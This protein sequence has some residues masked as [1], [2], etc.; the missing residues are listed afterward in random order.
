MNQKLIFASKNK[1]GVHHQSLTVYRESEY[2]LR[3]KKNREDIQQRSA[4]KTEGAGAAFR[5]EQTMMHHADPETIAAAAE[6]HGISRIDQDD[7]IVYTISVENFSGI[8]TKNLQQA[9]D[10]EG[11][12]VHQNEVRFMNLDYHPQHKELVISIDQ[13][14]GPGQHI[15][16]MN[17]GSPRYRFVTEGDCVDENPVWLKS[18]HRVIYYESAGIGRDQQGNYM[19]LG[20]KA[21]HR[22]DLESGALEEVVAFPNDDCILP[23]LDRSNHLFFIKRP[24]QS[25]NSSRSSSFKDLILMPYR[26][27]KAIFNWINFFTMRYTGETLTRG[28]DNPAKKMDPHQT[29]VA[30]NLIHAQKALKENQSK[31]EK[32]PGIVP[33]DWELV[34]MEKTGE[35]VT[36]KRG[37]LDYSFTPEGNIVYSNGNYVVLLTSDGNEEVLDKADRAQK[38][39]F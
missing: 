26:I 4:W 18:D 27:G 12:I 34:R 3:Y 19:G 1:I 15:A 9:N 5:G 32:Y 11:H 10:P 22:L 24:Y 8:F 37:V 7:V 38:L 17:M 30:G 29:F 39:T 16:I 36:V 23:K 35:L 20:P 31:G 13:A 25:G 28:N 14:Y 2:L 33:R 6:I 21:I